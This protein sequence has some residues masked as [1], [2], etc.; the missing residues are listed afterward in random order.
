M[1]YQLSQ[2]RKMALD[3]QHKGENA[4]ESTLLKI[5]DHFGGFEAFT[6][7]KI[8]REMKELRVH[9]LRLPN[10]PSDLYEQII[11]TVK[12]LTRDD[13][14]RHGIGS[15][16]SVFVN[17]P[18]F[19]R[20]WDFN[21]NGISLSLDSFSLKMAS[22]SQEWQTS[23]PWRK[24]PT[25]HDERCRNKADVFGSHHGCKSVRVF[26]PDIALD[27]AAS[28]RNNLF[29]I[30]DSKIIDLL[31][32]NIFELSVESRASYARGYLVNDDHWDKL[33]EDPHRYVLHGV[34]T[35]LLLPTEV[36]RKIVASH[37]TPDLREN[38]A[39]NTTDRTLLQEIWDGTKSE[40]IRARVK[41]N[42]FWPN[43]S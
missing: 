37:K 27:T 19:K 30:I 15:H 4:P 38:I 25:V 22:R 14:Y 39:L 9:L 10:F 33:A 2:V 6:N 35:N 12:K 11:T 8:D 36:A 17:Y 32:N 13:I 5:Y 43:P 3:L 24:F 40:S 34:T 28:I 42:S 20:L 23:K 21:P 29:K 41:E 16:P 1:S 7:P 18:L 26:H 31:Q